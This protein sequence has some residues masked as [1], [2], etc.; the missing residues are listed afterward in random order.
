[1]NHEIKKSLVRKCLYKTHL[2]LLGLHKIRSIWLKST[3]KLWWSCLKW[4]CLD[5]ETNWMKYIE[6][7][8]LFNAHFCY[9]LVARVS[10]H[11]RIENSVKH[12]DV[13]W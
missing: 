12:K 8:V 9:K 2:A 5:E 1:M 4:S 11:G 3:K 10:R 13:A 6:K 7:R